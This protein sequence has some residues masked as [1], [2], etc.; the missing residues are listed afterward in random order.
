MHGVV[1]IDVEVVVVIDYVALDDFFMLFL[2]YLF[3]FF[4]VLSKNVNT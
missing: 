3:L 2:T 1:D 4:L